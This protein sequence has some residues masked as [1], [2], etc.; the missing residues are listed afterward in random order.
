ILSGNTN[1]QIAGSLGISLRTVETHITNIFNK[2]GLA[3]R[4]ELVNYCT[5][6]YTPSN[7][8]N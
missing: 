4:A 5:D 6:L 7:E 8:P 1:R 3:T 2:L